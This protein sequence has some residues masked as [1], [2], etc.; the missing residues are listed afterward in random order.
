MINVKT[1]KGLRV[2]L[3]VLLIVV[4]AFG[5][6]ACGNKDAASG[7]SGDASSSGSSSSGSAP[8]NSAGKSMEEVLLAAAKNMETAES[9]TYTMNMDMGMTVFGMSIDSLMTADVKTISDPLAIE[10]KGSTDMGSLGAYNMEIYGESDGTNMVMYTG[11]ENEGK[12][13]WMKSTVDIDSSQ[14][15]Q[16]NAQSNIK[17]YMENAQN[18]KQVG[19]EEVN[20]VKA[21]RFDGVITG[22]SIGAALD[23]SGM[24]EQLAGSGIEDPKEFFDEMGDMFVSFWVDTENEQI[25]KYSIDMSA[26]MTN[27]MSKAMEQVAEEGGATTTE[28]GEEIDMAS[29]FS[30]ER[31][32]MDM[33][34]TGINNVDSIEV[35]AEAKDNAVE[36]AA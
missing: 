31:F 5:L 18:F 8:A 2:A 36:M 29:M 19:E 32:M 16:Y 27:L 15:S 4:M 30:I 23:E 24:K 34:I 11:M 13:E 7:T 10:L 3:A 35:P 28:D 21:V 14:I 33:T 17:V 25:V 1:K 12:M 9:M 26:A 20:G 6:A 22:D